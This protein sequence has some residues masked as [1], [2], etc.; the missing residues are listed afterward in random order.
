MVLISRMM[1][2]H[3]LAKA[4][5]DVLANESGLTEYKGDSETYNLY[6]ETIPGVNWKLMIKMP[7]SEINAPVQKLTIILI[8]VAAIAVIVCAIVIILIANSLSKTLNRVKAFAGDLA[9]GDFTVDKIN[10]KGK[11]ELGLMSGSLNEMYESNRDVI[12][13]I[14]TG[15]ANV[16]DSSSER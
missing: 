10:T 9:K 15:S 6:Y 7:V 12:S 5:E 2:T 1:R 11:D 8:I 3:P 4:G 16:N 13:S 14:S